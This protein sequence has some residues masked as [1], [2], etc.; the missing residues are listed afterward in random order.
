MSKAPIWR[1]GTDLPASMELRRAGA[2]RLLC[3]PSNRLVPSLATTV[4]LVRRTDSAPS[5]RGVGP[6]KRNRGE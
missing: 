5:R 1:S 2:R 6:R 4:A 3:T